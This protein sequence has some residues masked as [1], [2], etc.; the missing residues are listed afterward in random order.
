MIEQDL[1]QIIPDITATATVDNTTGT[2]E[3]NITVDE[4]E[5]LGKLINK[6][7]FSFL[8]MKGE[9]GDKPQKGVDYYTPQE[10][11]QFTTETKALVAGEGSKQVSLINAETTKV[12]QQIREIVAGNEATSNAITLS[13]K[14]RL[15]FEKET[16]GVA[17][18]F[19]GT[20]PLTQ[21]T[22]NAVY[23]VPQTGKFYV[24]TK[25]YSGGNLTAP[26]A[27]FEELSVWKNRDK[28]E[29]LSKISVDIN[30]IDKLTSKNQLLSLKKG[31]YYIHNI[32][33]DEKIFYNIPLHERRYC[34]LEVLKPTIDS[35][36]RL[37]T[38]SETVKEY[39]CFINSNGTIIGFS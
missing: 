33:S 29:N 5:E 7:K 1:G 27:N 6:F 24:C 25:E 35:F 18:G 36:F 13:G 38:F 30:V 3:V 8:H 4:I 34:L 9:K 2:P 23:L 20:F 16:Q 12:I 11:E 39:L 31:T 32:I 17:G 15:E 37:L 19:S 22:L 26:N 14:T 28:L 10:K 21:A